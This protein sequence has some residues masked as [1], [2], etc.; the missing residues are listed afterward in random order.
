MNQA[1][2]KAKKLL[3]ELEGFYLHPKKCP[4][5]KWTIGHGHNLEVNGLTAKEAQRVE[6]DTNA[7]DERAITRWRNIG[8][9]TKEIKDIL[10]KYEMAI[11]ASYATAD[12]ILDNDISGF[13]K[14]LAKHDYFTEAPENVQIALICIC[15]QCGFVGM[16]T[17]VFIFT[18]E[19]SPATGRKIYK[20]HYFIDYIKQKDYNR[21]SAI[22]RHTLI[23]RNTKNRA[24]RMAK[25]IYG[26]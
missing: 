14:Q 13:V 19:P 5:G 3:K 24:L 21:A 16:N 17:K 15:F 7:I 25:L 1:I 18:R 9:V 10:P 6:F 2:Q 12:Y 23:F 26:S 11:K 4:A 20:R 22:L 8:M